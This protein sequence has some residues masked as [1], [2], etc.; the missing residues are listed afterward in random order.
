MKPSLLALSAPVALVA[1]R[2]FKFPADGWMPFFPY[3]EVPGPIENPDGTTASVVQV[4]DRPAAEAVL[5]AFRGEAAKPNFGGVLVDIDHFSLDPA[6]ES[7]AAMWIDELQTRDDGVWFKSRVTNTGRTLLEGGDYRFISPVLEF[8]ARQY[9]S[10]DRVRPIGLHSAGLTNDPRIKGGLPL[11]N[12]Q[13]A[14]T[15]ERSEIQPT[16]KTVLKELGLADDASEQS[17]VAAVQTIRNRATKAEGDLVTLRTEHTELLAAQVESDLKEFEPVIANRDEVKAQLLAN[18][19]GTLIVLRGL[20]KPA[21]AKPDPAR[22]TNRG[23]A[24]TPAETP[25]EAEATAAKDKQRG[26]KIANRAAELRK[27]TPSLSRS[28]AFA[29]A[30]AELDAAK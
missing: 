29:K 23:A 21:E 9:R 2:D 18:R 25:A 19:K 16:M 11:S 20:K 22:I 15:A 28:A 12:R 6:K 1:N 27:L 8:P 26:A 30:E 24:R 17:A 14:A 13:T 5:A 7:R 10:G 4:L 3:G